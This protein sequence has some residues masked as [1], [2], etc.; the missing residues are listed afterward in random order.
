MQRILKRGN[1]AALTSPTL[2]RGVQRHLSQ[3]RVIG[4]TDDQ[5]LREFAPRPPP[6]GFR[7][8]GRVTA[9]L[10][11]DTMMTGLENMPLNADMRVTGHV[12]TL[13][14]VG[15]RGIGRPNVPFHVDTIM[16][17]RVN[18][19]LPVGSRVIGL[20]KERVL[21]DLVT[22]GRASA[23]FPGGSRVTGQ[24]QQYPGRPSDRGTRTDREDRRATARVRQDPVPR[25][26]IDRNR[27]AGTKATSRDRQDPMIVLIESRDL[28]KRLP[29]RGG[30]QGRR[31]IR[32]AN[33]NAITQRH[34]TGNRRL[35]PILDS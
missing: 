15:S 2:R 27:H 9:P 11:V 25:I 16:T 13:L 30:Q 22:T 29:I 19:P 28:R 33:Q 1:H 6:A 18:I 32:H 35:A 7:A 20:V 17:G 21:A 14:L 26:E 4:R 34:A 5:I 23:P 24:D 31:R 8:A 10:H 12:N 3:V